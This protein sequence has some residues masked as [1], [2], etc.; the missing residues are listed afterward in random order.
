[1]YIKFI[2]FGVYS[3]S[4]KFLDMLIFFEKKLKILLLLKNM[5]FKNIFYLFFPILCAG[6]GAFSGQNFIC[7]PCQTRLSPSFKKVP[8]PLIH[9]EEVRY[10]YEYSQVKPYLHRIKFDSDLRT[11]KEFSKLMAEYPLFFPSNSLFIP[12]PLHPKKLKKRGYNQ[13]QEL[14]SPFFEYHRMTMSPFL[15]RIK[16]TK[17]Q[18][19]LNKKERWNNVKDAFE[20]SPQVSGRHVVLLEDVV[21]TGAT[22]AHAALCLKQNGALSISVLALSWES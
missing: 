14:F 6:C 4:S 8:Y 11:L 21:T 17:P 22:I 18:F 7:Q 1:M 5:A 16:E 15:F 10:F 20:A 19:S 12:I 13:V 3:V 2:E 9:I